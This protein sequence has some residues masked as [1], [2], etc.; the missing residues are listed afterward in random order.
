M[1]IALTLGSVVSSRYVNPSF[2]HISTLEVT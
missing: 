2:A 1:A